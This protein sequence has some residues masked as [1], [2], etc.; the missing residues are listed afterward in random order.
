MVLMWICRKKRDAGFLGGDGE[1]LSFRPRRDPTKGTIQ[2]LVDHSQIHVRGEKIK[3]VSVA[4]GSNPFN[5]W[6][7]PYEEI[8]EDG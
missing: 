1:V 5:H 6:E 2:S 8:E 3:I 7:I 4:R